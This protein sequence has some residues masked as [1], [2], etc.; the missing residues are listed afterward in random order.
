[1]H[2]GSDEGEAA[3]GGS[4]WGRMGP[5]VVIALVLGWLLL[6]GGSI[7]ALSVLW[8]ELPG[9]K[10]LVT[11]ANGVMLGLILIIVNFV[12]RMPRD[13]GPLLQDDEEA[14]AKSPEE[15]PSADEFAETGSPGVRVTDDDRPVEDPK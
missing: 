14:A 10:G 8:R 15:I 4:G 5:L 1:M 12:W 2:E 3:G 7:P 13:G 11:I 6:S 9:T